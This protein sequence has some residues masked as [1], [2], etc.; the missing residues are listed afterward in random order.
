[1]RK[2]QLGLPNLSPDFP[3]V[4]GEDYGDVT[5]EVDSE[6]PGD[7]DQFTIVD[8]NYEQSPGKLPPPQPPS[9]THQIE[10]CTT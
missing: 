1:M 3:E 2:F 9:S 8:L 7:E 6:T 5:I 4:E 10:A